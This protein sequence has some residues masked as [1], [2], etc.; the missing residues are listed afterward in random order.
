MKSV[1]TIAAVL[2]FA[3][4][5]MPAVQAQDGH[6]H[7][8]P[9]EAS[10]QDGRHD[11]AP[12]G[13]SAQETPATR[14]ATDAPLRKGMGEIR[15]AVDA[16]NHY[17]RGHM[18]SEQAVEFAGTIRQQVDYLIANCKLDPKADAAL[19]VII[20]RL[21][22]S[23]QALQSDPKDLTSIPPM[24]EA[25]QQYAV[26]FDDPDWTVGPEEPEEAQ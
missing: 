3:G 9:A 15:K 1:V 5:A 21:A 8:E 12:A 22:S 23:A 20:A 11:H 25:L 7:H 19:H 4:V 13:E 16:L 14:F 26:Q 6:H 18:G 24:R 2:L 10:A 17:E